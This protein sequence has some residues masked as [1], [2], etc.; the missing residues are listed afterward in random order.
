MPRHLKD[1]LATG[2]FVLTAE[3]TPPVSCDPPTCSPRQ[4]PLKGLADA[5]NVTDGA[6]ARAHLAR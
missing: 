5:V 3:I 4:L 2:R 6:G 1:K